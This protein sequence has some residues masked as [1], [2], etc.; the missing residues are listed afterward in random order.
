MIIFVVYKTRIQ[1]NKLTF[2]F[3]SSYDSYDDAKEMAESEKDM[4]IVPFDE[5][6]WD[7]PETYFDDS[8]E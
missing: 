6:D 1:D 8:K 2:E 7:D 3:W 5:D 4:I